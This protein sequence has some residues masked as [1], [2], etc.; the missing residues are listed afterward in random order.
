MGYLGRQLKKL[1]EDYNNVFEDIDYNQ[2]L[3]LKNISVNLETLPTIFEV[4]I[5]LLRCS[6]EYIS[7]MKI[8]YEFNTSDLTDMKINSSETTQIENCNSLGSDGSLGS[9]VHSSASNKKHFSPFNK[10]NN[11]IVKTIFSKVSGDTLMWNMS[12]VNDS[13]YR[14]VSKKLADSSFSVVL[15]VKDPL[16]REKLCK[17]KS[18]PILRSTIQHLTIRKVGFEYLTENENEQC[19]GLLEK[20]NNLRVLNIDGIKYSITNNMDLFCKLIA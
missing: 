4:L 17:L 7:K 14:Q 6:L 10:L 3:K 13:F 5:D 12:T 19:G 11:D 2:F 9:I 1:L 20:L 15:D 16:F 8:Q 18:F